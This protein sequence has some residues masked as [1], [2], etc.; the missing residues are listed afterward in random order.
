M[1]LTLALF[2]LSDYSDCAIRVYIVTIFSVI[3]KG[4]ESNEVLAPKT[5]PALLRNCVL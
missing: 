1:T 2:K 4:L 5:E 3:V